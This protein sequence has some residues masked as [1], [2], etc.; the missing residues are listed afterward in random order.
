MEIET[1]KPS[2]NANSS[3]Y[4]ETRLRTPS[5][6]PART[7]KALT[8]KQHIENHKRFFIERKTGEKMT[9]IDAVWIMNVFARMRCDS[10]FYDITYTDILFKVCDWRCI[11]KQTLHKLQ[12]QYV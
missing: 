6:T 4:R 7:T 3:T 9:I 12:R 10:L 8:I 5:R 2:T 11:S 1:Q